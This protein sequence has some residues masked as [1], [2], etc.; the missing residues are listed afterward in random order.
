L[1]RQVLVLGATVAVAT[2]ITGSTAVATGSTAV[3]AATLDSMVQETT[4]T[5]TLITG[6]SVT[7]TTDAGRT[8]VAVDQHQP[9]A[10][11]D[12]RDAAGDEH[13]IP[14]EAQPYLGH[15]LD[16]SLFNVSALIRDGLTGAARIPVTLSYAAGTTPIA[17]P[18]IT[19]TN[20]TGASATGY[21]TSS[22]SSGF[23]AALRRQIGADV[24]AGR[25]AGTTA[26]MAGLTG[27]A[28][29]AATGSILTPQYAL[30][31]LHINVNDNAGAPADDL[32]VTLVNTDSVGKQES[33]V[34][35]DNGVGQVEVPAG[36]YSAIV[37]SADFDESGD[38]T[39][40]RQ[41]TVQ[42]FTVQAV[43][44]P[45]V[46]SIS[47][48]SATTPLT[49]SVP[50]GATPGPVVV[51]EARGDAQGGTY[52]DIFDVVGLPVYVAPTAAPAVGTS[53][54]VVGSSATATATHS[55]YDVAFSTNTGVPADESY[56]INPVDLATVRQKLFA[57]PTNSGNDVVFVGLQDPELPQVAFGGSVWVAPDVLTHYFGTEDGGTWTQSLI[58]SNSSHW[59]ASSM[60]FA[61]GHEYTQD[62]GH[63]PLPIDFGSHYDGRQ[64]CYAC[65]SDGFL[66]LQPNWADDSTP[67]HTGIGGN[68]LIANTSATLYQNGT[69]LPTDPNDAFVELSNIPQTPTTYR[70]VFD[71][72]AQAGA[73]YSQSLDTHTDLT[74]N[75]TPTSDAQQELP[76]QD[77]CAGSDE[78]AASGA[79]CKILPILSVNYQLATDLTNTSRSPVQRLGLTIGHVSYDGHCSRSPIT[80]T[81]L[82]IS[83]N[84]GT[85]W[86]SV[87]LLGASGHYLALWAN[88]HVTSATPGPE[89][90]VTAS[91]AAGGTITQTVSAAYTIGS[92]Q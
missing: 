26:P 25:P 65:T 24:A 85:T 27:I 4:S 10:Y 92:A 36:H 37:D 62:W 49:V 29:D 31:P 57:D 61:A 8:G 5:L 66:L 15:F 32:D 55:Q 86:Q 6:E 11:H 17:P 1:S 81:R 60:S 68:I 50:S 22:S 71:H 80:S 69:E 83:F 63:G 76:D 38:P 84:N 79:A 3:S 64:S 70:V 34:P 18:G 30:Y 75:Y 45:T 74:F 44:S 89:L 43:S 23:A 67:G 51:Y 28:L 90:K 82:A 9:D 20:S 59:S 56:T 33:E 40:V 42:D 48:S 46:L 87:P 77:Q 73:G 35:I 14:V 16:P 7:V 41:V 52:E 53:H 13:V 19:L 88:P 47:E 39:A 78:T 91:D 2:V 12:Y 58:S 54:F 72:A 21:L